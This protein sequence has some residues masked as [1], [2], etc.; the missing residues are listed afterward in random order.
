MILLTMNLEFLS[1]RSVN[2]L[3]V[4]KRFFNEKQLV[5]ELVGAY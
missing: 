4:D 1:G 5:F 2:E 3:A